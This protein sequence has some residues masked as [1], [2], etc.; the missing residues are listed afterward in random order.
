MEREKKDFLDCVGEIL[1]V[2]KRNQL[3]SVSILKTY[4]S[5]SSYC[6]S[7]G[8]AAIHIPN[9]VNRTRFVKKV[10][11]FVPL[12]YA[13]AM[14]ISVYEQFRIHIMMERF[15]DEIFG[16]FCKDSMCLLI[17]PR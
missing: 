17:A 5:K 12:F 13:F 3:S 14:S 4:G 1:Q 6:G 11:S 7:V 16:L 8:E 2:L 9:L 15:S 10:V